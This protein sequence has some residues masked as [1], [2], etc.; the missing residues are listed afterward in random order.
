MDLKEENIL[1]D[2]ISGHWYYKS[3]AS[4]LLRL[5]GN[6]GYKVIL[7]IGAGSGFF[8]KYL[9]INTSAE[10]GICIDISYPNEWHE[11]VTGKKVQFLNNY[12]PVDADLVLLMDVLEHVDNDVQLLREYVEKAP[13]GTRF[14]ISVPAFNF[15]WSNHDIFLEH[16]R[17]YTLNTLRRVVCNAGLREQSICY[18]FGIV[19]PLV[20]AVRLGQQLFMRENNS[21]PKS[22]L[23]VHGSVTNTLLTALCS[24][25]LPFFKLNKLAGLSI[26]CLCEK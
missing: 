14:L 3:K 7:D 5:V 18:Y 25:E 15:L 26:F 10:K 24:V 6:G 8:T 16:R 17:R 2:G 12:G 1:G 22:D 21:S 19:F 23:K 4:A 11:Y 20:A 9:L 13:Q